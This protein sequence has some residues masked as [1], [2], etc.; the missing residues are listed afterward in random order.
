MVAPPSTPTASS[1]PS[2]PGAQLLSMQMLVT[3]NTPLLNVYVMVAEFEPTVSVKVVALA[4]GAAETTN[5]TATKARI[6][7]FKLV[8]RTDFSPFWVFRYFSNALLMAR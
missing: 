3:V 4:R 7:S 5:A 6:E 8:I 1:F 2:S